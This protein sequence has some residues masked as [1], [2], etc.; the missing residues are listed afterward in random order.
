MGTRSN[1]YPQSMFLSIFH[2]FAPKHILLVLVLMSAHNLCFGAKMRKIGTPLY[3]P[4]LLHTS[5]V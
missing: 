1:E 5:G 3:T 4:V 2:I